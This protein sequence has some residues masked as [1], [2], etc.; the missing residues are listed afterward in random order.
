MKLDKIVAC[1]TLL[2]LF[3]GSRSVAEPSWIE[4]TSP[5]ASWTLSPSNPS[6]SSTIT[7]RGPLDTNS[8]GNSCAAEASLGGTPKLSI[9]ILSKVIQL[10]FQGPPPTECPLIYKPVCG[11][12]G[13]FGPLT[14]GKWTFRCQALGVEIPFTVTASAVIYVDPVA[15]GP[16][17]GSS[18]QRAY[19]NV[20]DALAAAVSG[21]EIWVAGGTYTPDVGGGQTAGD[22]AASFDVPDGV[23]LRGGYGGYL[24]LSP[25]ARD[26]VLHPTVL[27]GD[28]DG[29]DLWGILN[30]DDNSYH[31][32]T[33]SGD[34][35]LD[36]LTVMDGQAN[37]PYPQH[38]GGGLY[39][40]GGHPTLLHCTFRGNS[41][42][43]GGAVAALGGEA[44]LA[45]C[46]MSGN[47]A[48]LYGGG[49]YN[50]DSATTLANCL[51]T[52]NSAGTDGVGGGSA[53]CNMG[54]SAARVTLSGCTLADNVG[55]WPSE[56]VIF[57]F[58]YLGSPVPTPQTLVIEN[59]IVYN[60]GG[61]SPIWS[62]N[63]SN[64][65]VSR[66]L[67]QGGWA[68]PANLNADP[69]FVSRGL[70]SIEG[71][72][73]DAGSDYGLEASSPAIDAGSNSLIPSDQADVD[74]DGDVGE[75][76]PIDLAEQVRV[77]NGQ[78]DMGAY[79]RLAVGPVPGPGPSPGPAWVELTKFGITFDVPFGVTSPVTLNGAYSH[80]IE[81]NFKAEVKLAVTST[82]TAGGTWTVWFDP[83]P[84]AVGPG[85][86]MIGW[87]VKGENVAIN[88]LTPG[89][90]DVEVAEVTIYVRPAP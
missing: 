87:R 67:V 70:W 38:C 81:T 9:N 51:M 46:N 47:R 19:R 77:A 41:G 39:I 54:G 1:V 85:S 63:L 27:S 6:P 88:L 35:I 45:N 71:E 64:V 72:W 30:R 4:G 20:Q 57:N 7:Y 16:A 10:W 65:G 17:D 52:G 78:V 12:E 18:W 49:L 59:S 28:L 62:A 66:S 21:D 34:A 24:A 15:T 90:T 42:V 50:Y 31:V 75:D 80:E 56:W 55:P 44:Y 43:N 40:Q 36:G 26:I 69:Q 13:T 86:T 33:S 29:D 60:D 48:L 89:S 79:E 2:V 73:I 58:N 74:R 76:H 23:I 5:P 3:V 53:I 37:G 8:Y 84:G 25:D 61:F 22:R 68:G 32:V 14:A 82:S 11:L 83:D